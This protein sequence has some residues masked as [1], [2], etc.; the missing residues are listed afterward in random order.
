MP[1]PILQ[2][3]VLADHVYQDRV[4][5]KF[6]IAGTF[7]TIVHSQ[8][9]RLPD[10]GRSEIQGARQVFAGPLTQI[11]SPY[12]YLALAEIH[13]QVPLQLKFVDLSDASVRFDAEFEV[14]SIDPVSVS[15]YVL[16][17][18]S[19]PAE[20]LGTYSLDLLYDGEIM[21]SWRIDVK[22]MPQQGE[23]ATD[24]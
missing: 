2:A 1:K 10:D 7:S 6:I 17:M 16:Q 20:K 11:G 4:T 8:V 23:A 24:K 9:A 19:L 5:G 21:G 18:P 22:S 3:M 15:E 12:L 14:T 13:G